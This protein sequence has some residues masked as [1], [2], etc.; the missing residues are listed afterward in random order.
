MLSLIAKC[1]NRAISKLVWR[2]LRKIFLPEFPKVKAVGTA[3]AAGLYQRGPVPG[4]EARAK[5][6]YGSPTRSAREPEPTPAATPALSVGFVTLKGV[7]VEV[8]IIPE[9]CHPPSKAWRSPAPLKNG[10]SQ[11]QLKLKIC[12][13]SK[14]ELARFEAKLYAFTKLPSPRSEESSME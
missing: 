12:L 1:L 4:E 10:T 6:A 11:I 5:P 2:G 14:L 7:P 13:W 9:Y 3:K 8:P